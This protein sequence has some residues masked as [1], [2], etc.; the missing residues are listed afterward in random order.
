MKTLIKTCMFLE[1]PVQAGSDTEWKNSSES[2]MRQEFGAFCCFDVTV[3]LSPLPWSHHNKSTKF[4][5]F[6]CP[7]YVVNMLV[8][9]LDLTKSCLLLSIILSFLKITDIIIFCQ[10]L[11]KRLLFHVQL[12]HS[13]PTIWK[14]FSKYCLLYI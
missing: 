5:F 6:F 7:I 10:W 3:C 2:P 14:H 8:Y 12:M 13:V 11:Q 4:A 9:L 1:N